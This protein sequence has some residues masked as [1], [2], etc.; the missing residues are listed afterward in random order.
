MDGSSN[1]KGNRVGIILEDQN[2]V[3]IEQFLRFMFKTNN[4]QIGY[5]AL[6]TGLRLAK[7]LGVQRVVIKGDSQLIIG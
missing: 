2:E 3:S 5:K 7:E 1:N 4:N 6:L